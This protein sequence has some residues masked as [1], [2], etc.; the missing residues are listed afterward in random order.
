MLHQFL[1]HYPKESHPHRFRSIHSGRA[2]ASS[3]SA[4]EFDDSSGIAQLARD[5]AD[6]VRTMGQVIDRSFK[7]FTRN[8]N[9][10]KQDELGQDLPA[11]IMGVEAT[12]EA[13]HWHS[14]PCPVL[15]RVAVPALPANAVAGWL[16]RTALG[17]EAPAPHRV[18]MHPLETSEPSH[19]HCRMGMYPAKTAGREGR[20]PGHQ[21]GSWSVTDH[22]VLQRPSSVG[23]R[24][25]VPVRPVEPRRWPPRLQSRARCNR[26]RAAPPACAGRDR[27]AGAGPR[28]RS[29]CWRPECQ[30]S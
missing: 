26:S 15:K 17:L 30:R 1:Q 12:G 3:L 11:E 6:V 4:T 16:S 28:V 20:R 13:M 19:S 14:C 23:R 27:V 2:V 25:A 18:C 5:N 21:R 29:C 10:T 22:L 24:S 8:A 7:A 9:G